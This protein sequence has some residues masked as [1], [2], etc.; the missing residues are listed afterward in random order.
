M[1]LG[2][3]RYLSEAHA[4]VP[5]KFSCWPWRLLTTRLLATQ[6]NRLNSATTSMISSK[7][8][9]MPNPQVQP[10]PNGAAERIAFICRQ[11]R[12]AELRKLC[13]GG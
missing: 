8:V 5:D 11:S 2:V 6:I 13:G 3:Y 7:G 1:G 9:Q 10:T 4:H 12:L